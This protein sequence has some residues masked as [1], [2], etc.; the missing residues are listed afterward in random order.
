MDSE[1]PLTTD[2]LEKIEAEMKKI[3]KEA[4]PITRFT[5]SRAEAIEFFTGKN[6]P[7][8]VELI[9]DLPEDCGSAFISRESLSIFAQVPI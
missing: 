8:K 6:E 5:K 7:Y 4:L 2:D 9:E 1:E 3:V